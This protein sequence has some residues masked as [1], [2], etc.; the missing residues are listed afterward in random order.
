MDMKLDILLITLAVCSAALGRW[1]FKISTIFF[2][3]EKKHKKKLN[4]FLILPFKRVSSGRFYE[5]HFN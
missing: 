1:K 4:L 2:L 3:C 5:K